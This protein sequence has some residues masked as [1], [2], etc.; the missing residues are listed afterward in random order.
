MRNEIIHNVGDLFDFLANNNLD[1]RMH[2]V[3]HSCNAQGVM[4]AGFAA[5]VKNKFPNCFAAYL[6]GLSVNNSLS[7]RMGTFS[8]AECSLNNNKFCIINIIGQM[9][10]GNDPNVRYTS[11]DAIDKS[12]TSIDEILSSTDSEVVFHFPKIGS[13]RGGGS[14]DVISEIIKHRLN[15]NHYTLNLWELKNG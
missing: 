2:V 4:G 8:A 6:E 12:L 14:W 13:V 15:R 9:Y 7:R 10:Y 5:V 1:D 3:L 11:Y